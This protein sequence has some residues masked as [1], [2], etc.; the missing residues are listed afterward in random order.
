M[1]ILQIPVTKFGLFLILS[2]KDGLNKISEQ[3]ARKNIIFKLKYIKTNNY[4][5]SA[6]NII[7][8]N[9]NSCESPENGAQ[10]C[11]HKFLK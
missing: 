4:K 9:W 1:K 3:I 8:N 10:C 6:F 5:T 11:K 2:V 7:M